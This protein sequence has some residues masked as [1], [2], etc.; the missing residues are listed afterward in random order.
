MLLHSESHYAATAHD[1]DYGDALH[2]FDLAQKISSH[3]CKIFGGL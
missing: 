1:G 3:A 2:D